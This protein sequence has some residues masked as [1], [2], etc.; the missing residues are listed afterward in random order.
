VFVPWNGQAGFLA[1]FHHPP[2]EILRTGVYRD[3]S[4]Q[5]CRVNVGLF[6]GG[7]KPKRPHD[8]RGATGERLAGDQVGQRVPERL[9]GVERVDADAPVQHR[10]PTVL[11][12]M[13]RRGPVVGAD[14]QHVAVRDNLGDHDQLRPP[15]R[16]EPVVQLGAG[17]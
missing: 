6:S 12:R 2:E 14:R 8:S 7:Y 9:G 1:G 4:A 11:I 13:W 16:V 3:L 10:R 17:Q 5:A 15:G